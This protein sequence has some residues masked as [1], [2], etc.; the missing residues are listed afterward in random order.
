MKHNYV[1][2][3][4]DWKR[5]LALSS[6]T[7]EMTRRKKQQKNASSF[8]LVSRSVLRDLIKGITG[9]CVRA[10]DPTCKGWA[11]VQGKLLP[12]ILWAWPFA[13]LQICVTIDSFLGF[14]KHFLC[15][16]ELITSLLCIVGEEKD[17]LGL[18]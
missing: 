14:F 12:A 6:V 4:P 11:D 10:S 3:N 16:E 1:F 15:K 2:S 9:I 13:F 5:E 17:G 18:K 7:S 8:V